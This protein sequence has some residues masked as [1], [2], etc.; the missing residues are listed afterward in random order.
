MVF[1]WDLAAQL[2]LQSEVPDAQ[3]GLE[4]SWPSTGG[5]IFRNFHPVL[6]RDGDN[7]TYLASFV[8]RPMLVLGAANPLP[9]YY[10]IPQAAAAAGND[11]PARL[12]WPAPALT[13]LRGK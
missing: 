7:Y 5:Y 3:A 13:I 6:D 1:D 9:C 4:G 10:T 11:G 8:A 2:I 12:K